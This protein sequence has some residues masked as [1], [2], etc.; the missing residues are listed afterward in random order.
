MAAFAVEG[1]PNEPWDPDQ[2]PDLPEYYLLSPV[3]TSV[4]DIEKQAGQWVYGKRRGDPLALPIDADGNIIPDPDKVKLFF[5]ERKI[6]VKSLLD[7]SGGKDLMYQVYQADPQKKAFERASMLAVSRYREVPLDQIGGVIDLTNFRREQNPKNKDG[8][9]FYFVPLGRDG[10]HRLAS[11]SG[12]ELQKLF[13]APAPETD[14]V[15]VHYPQD[16]PWD[17]T[18]PGTLMHYAAH[19]VEEP[20]DMNQPQATGVVYI[21]MSSGNPLVSYGGEFKRAFEHN[22]TFLGSMKNQVLAHHYTIPDVEELE[23]ENPALPVKTEVTGDET[24]EAEYEKLNNLIQEAVANNPDRD[25]TDFIALANPINSARFQRD[26][27]MRQ[28][29]YID[30]S[31]SAILPNSFVAKKVGGLVLDLRSLVGHQGVIIE[32]NPGALVSE[33]ITKIQEALNKDI[34]YRDSWGVSGT[35][36]YQNMLEKGVYHPPLGYAIERKKL[37]VAY[38]GDGNTPLIVKK[39]SILSGPL[40]IVS[41][42]AII[43]VGNMGSMGMGANEVIQ[44]KIEELYRWMANAE[45]ARWRIITPAFRIGSP[46]SLKQIEDGAFGPLNGPTSQPDVGD[47]QAQI[48]QLM[49]LK[50]NLLEYLAFLQALRQELL[51]GGFTSI[52]D[53]I[54][55]RDQIEAIPADQRTNAQI[56]TLNKANALIAKTKDGP[57]PTYP[58]SFS[59]MTTD[60]LYAEIQKTQQEIANIQQ[61]IDVLKAQ[62]EA[63]Q[64]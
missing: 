7:P 25:T 3:A 41:D 24:I 36:A 4:V 55:K 58:P 26:R 51:D 23:L 33:A 1:G 59:G 15:V 49:Q 39:G 34:D 13:N 11:D 37:L 35:P 19:K 5:R 29:Q 30:E 63:L 9:P 38:H 16:M 21:R 52:S 17:L 42:E 60:D 64:S 18:R 28:I 27:L 62:L 12:I 45:E 8:N 32:S 40:Q 61:K 44:Q 46:S 20:V 2:I 53:A 47:I 14:D 22:K 10:A 31:M 6:G 56:D 54:T 57:P 48:M 43:L 50:A